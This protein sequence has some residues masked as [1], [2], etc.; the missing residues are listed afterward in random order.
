MKHSG[1][2]LSPE[3]SHS[4]KMSPKAQWATALGHLVWAPRLLKREKSNR[5][6]D[7]CSAITL[8][9]CL[10][11]LSLMLMAGLP[12]VL[13]SP[14]TVHLSPRLV[15]GF[16]DPVAPHIAMHFLRDLCQPFSLVK[17]CLQLVN[18]HISHSQMFT[19]K[20]SKQPGDMAYNVDLQEDASRMGAEVSLW[21]RVEHSPQSH[22]LKCHLQ[23]EGTQPLEH[24]KE[25]W[26]SRK[27]Q[28]KNKEISAAGLS[29]RRPG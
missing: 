19:E 14:F 29:L 1:A 5:T 16:G 26:A 3:A 6:A 27:K 22:L 8:P 28:R 11:S 13:F 10:L 21:A 7:P 18:Q 20:L 17:G 15:N 4:G 12:V 9:T 25:A 23:S 2:P 24:Q